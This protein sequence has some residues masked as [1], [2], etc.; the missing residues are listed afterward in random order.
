[1]WSLGLPVS[2]FLLCL[3]Q[4][5]LLRHLESK[6]YENFFQLRSYIVD[7]SARLFPHAWFSCDCCQW[8]V[9]QTWQPIV[10]LREQQQRNSSSEVKQQRFVRTGL[11]IVDPSGLQRKHG[12]IVDRSAH[13]RHGPDPGGPISV[14]FSFLRTS[15]DFF[16]TLYRVGPTVGCLSLRLNVL[17][18]NLTFQIPLYRLLLANNT[19]RGLFALG[20]W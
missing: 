7:M 17:D 12:S 1:M 2:L 18:R 15:I 6:E 10:A 4:K 20:Y 11:Y 14:H 8:I 9:L 19:V 5:W 13:T 16:N 3:W